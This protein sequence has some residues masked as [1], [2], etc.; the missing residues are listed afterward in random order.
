MSAAFEAGVRAQ[1]ANLRAAAQAMREALG[2]V[3][4]R[5][6]R[7]GTLVFSGIGASWHAL[8]PA[9]RALRAAGRRAVAIP[10]AELADAPAARLG[11]AFVLVSQSGASSETVAALERLA[12]AHTVAVTADPGSPLARG[13]TA[14][15]PLGPQPDTAVSTLGYT[16]TLQALGMLADAILA[17]EGDWATVGDLAGRTLAASAAAADAT[18]RPMAGIRAVDAVGAGASAGSAGAAAL[19]VREALRLPATAA[20]TREYLHG[21]MEPVEPGF[22]C[23]VFGAGRERRLAQALASYGAA[24]ALVGH[25]AAPAPGVRAFPLPQAEPLAMPVLEILPVQLVVLRLAA[26]RGLDIAGLRRRQ[27]DTKL[28][29][30]RAA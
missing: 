30:G 5:P 26:A 9:V 2:Y 1:P 16:A 14:R 20:E 13:A 4:L 23:F 10:P 7:E 22:G 27:D 15:L 12:G 11:D 19:L 24:V 21:P 28:P 3:D 6:L 25:E 29:V 17:R 8:V 18:A